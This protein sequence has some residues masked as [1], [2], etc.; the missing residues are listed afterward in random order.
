MSADWQTMHTLSGKEF[1]LQ[2]D[3][4]IKDWLD[5]YIPIDEQTKVRLSFEEAIREKKM[6]ELEHKIIQADGAIGW[7]ASRAVPLLDK[8]GNITEWLGAA[9]DIS[10]RKKWEERLRQFNMLLEEEVRKQTARLKESH[11]QLQSVL[12]TS[13]MQC[14]FCRQ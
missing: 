12:D 9:S 10:A 5:V 6:F 8:D 3:H 7:T 2:T 1:L 13:M 4:P 14:L 11:D